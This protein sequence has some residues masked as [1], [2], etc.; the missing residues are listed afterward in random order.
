M[1]VLANDGTLPLGADR[2]VALVGVPARETLL[3]GGG[4][5]EVSPPHQV[6]ILDGLVG[7]YDGQVV[8]AG[9]V[10]IGAAPAARPGFVLD[11]VDGRPGL[12]LRITTA[13]GD[14]LT[15]EHL[16]DTRRVLGWRGELD[17]PGTR[18]RLTARIEPRVRCRSVSSGSGP[19]RSP[20]AAAARRCRSRR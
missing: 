18:A 15:E 14:L 11:P 12:R 8:Y 7:A 10:E 13:D 3:M 16:A 19:G 9:G 1:T 5:A 6:S 4:S 2:S 17:R 20:P